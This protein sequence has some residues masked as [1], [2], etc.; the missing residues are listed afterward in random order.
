MADHLV[1]DLNSLHINDSGGGKQI[2][3]VT[4][5]FMESWGFPLEEVYKLAMQFYKEKDGKA[6][7]LTYKDKVKLVAYTKQVSHGKYRPD[8]SPDVGFLDVVGNDRRQA[9]QAMGDM[10][11]TTAMEEF[12]KQLDSICPLFRPY[13]EAHRT[14]KEEKFK[15]EREDAERRKQE[16]EERERK[17]LEEEAQRQ[18][19]LERQRQLE[20]E[21][22]IRVALNQQTAVQFRQY[23]EQ[24]YPGDPKQQEELIKQLQEQH[25]Q[26]Y[27][28]QVYQQQV[29]H[30]QQQYRQLQAMAATQNGTVS[31]NPTPTH[32]HQALQEH[33]PSSQQNGGEEEPVSNGQE[34]ASSQN[35]RDDDELPPIAAASIW[36]RKDVKEFKDNLRKDKDSVIKVGSG[37]TVTVRVP[38]HE[39]GSCLFWEFA[40]DYYDIGFGVYFEWTVSPSNTVSVHVSESSDEEEEEENSGKNDV[41]K[42]Q[43]DK[44]DDRPP[45]DEIIP[46]YRRDCHEEVYCG[47]H[48][49]P[50]RGVY[51]L[52]FDNSYSLWRSKTLYYRVYYSR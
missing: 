6:L 35:E 38:T 31:H 5:V 29:L 23:A 14:E 52:K 21:M 8:A 18:L 3:N 22:Q 28:Q 30:Q 37:E 9:W 32:A 49:Y 17:M 47:S 7:H 24:Q 20:Q 41:E 44:K 1:N 51:L 50:G 33:V 11:R 36:T 45:T 34:D 25:F 40:T 19:Q 48:A 15:K 12:I 27:M 42:G 16:E 13:I 43:E 26:Q 39:D 46:V 4:D 10:S 2:I